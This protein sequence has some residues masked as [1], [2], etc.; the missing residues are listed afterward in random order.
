MFGGLR[1]L[2]RVSNLTETLD[3]GCIKADRY[4]EERAFHEEKYLARAEE[5]LAVAPQA[6][7]A[8]S[9]LKP[10]PSLNLNPP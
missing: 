2:S 6:S 1:P 9:E 4:K 5:L 10:E 8:G 7:T 3:A